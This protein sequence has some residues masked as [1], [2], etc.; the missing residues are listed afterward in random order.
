MP[1]T[2][3]HPIRSKIYNQYQMI[4]FLISDFPYMQSLWHKKMTLS[5]RRESSEI[6]EGDKEIMKSEFLQMASSYEGQR[7]YDG[8]FYNAMLVLVFSYY[9][10]L[11]ISIHNSE[12]PNSQ[13]DKIPKMSDFC[14]KKGIKLSSES[15]D[16]V[17]FI[18]N[19]VRLLRNY[20]THSKWGRHDNISSEIATLKSLEEEYTDIYMDSSSI[21]LL[22]NTFLLK[23][24][25][26]ERDVLLELSD[27][28]G[29]TNRSTDNYTEKQ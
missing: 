16:S 27:K 5:F 25:I 14:A 3:L 1:F 18:I 20:I 29:Y 12:F 23:A 11:I 4:E 21:Y 2:L 8:Y 28:L 7:D 19:K 15:M 9:E 26:K 22:G 10:D 17:E 6:S 13:T 24:L